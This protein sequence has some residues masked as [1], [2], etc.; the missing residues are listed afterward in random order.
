MLHAL[1]LHPLLHRRPQVHLY[2][3]CCD[4]YAVDE[5]DALRQ[6]R[7]FLSY[8]PSSVWELPARVQHPDERCTGRH[9]SPGCRFDWEFTIL[10]LCNIICNTPACSCAAPFIP[11]IM[12]GRMDW[13]SPY[14][15]E[16]AL[17][18]IIPNERHLSYDMRLVL[19]LVF[20]RDSW[21]EVCTCFSRHA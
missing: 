15:T 19:Q 1:L 17:S 9:L 11:S 8:M 16:I 21:F 2:N 12:G 4:N 10:L 13:A 6:L 3:G 20:D 5:A 7:Q 18:S 14:R